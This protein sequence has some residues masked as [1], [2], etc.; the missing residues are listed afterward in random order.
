M[1]AAE[2]ATNDH[3]TS[4]RALSFFSKILAAESAVP[5]ASTGKMGSRYLSCW[6]E[7]SQKRYI[8][9]ATAAKI[10]ASTGMSNFQSAQIKSGRPARNATPITPSK[11]SGCS[12][13]AATDKFHGAAA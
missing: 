1:P 3:F 12:G 9:P 2:A 5:I 4:E 13:W 6:L 11:N 7:N 8:V 10:F